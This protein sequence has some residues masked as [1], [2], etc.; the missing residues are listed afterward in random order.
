MHPISIVEITPS[1]DVNNITSITAGRLTVN[2]I[3]AAVRADYFDAP[4]VGYPC[5]G[6]RSNRG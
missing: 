4:R 2:M 1:A 6:G 3:G 5:W